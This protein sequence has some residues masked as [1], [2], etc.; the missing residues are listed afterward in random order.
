MIMIRRKRQTV[1]VNTASCRASLLRNL[2]L[3]TSYALYS[4]CITI[5]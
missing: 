5:F 1:W 4:L 3:I 2:S